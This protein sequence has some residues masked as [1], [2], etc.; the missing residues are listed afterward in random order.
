MNPWT[1][2]AQLIA[3]GAKQIVTVASVG[4]DGTSVV[5]LRNGSSMRVAGDTVAAGQKAFI[6]NG[7]IIGR[8]PDL[9]V[10]NVEV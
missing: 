1:K 4:S 10:Q 6:Q 7:R 3:P 8:A 5:T 2:F 9:P